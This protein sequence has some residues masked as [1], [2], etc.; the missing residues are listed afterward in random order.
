MELNEEELFAEAM[1]ADVLHLCGIFTVKG[2]LYIAVYEDGQTLSNP[3][4]LSE[5]KENNDTA[6][7]QIVT[8]RSGLCVK[9]PRDLLYRLV[10][11][12]SRNLYAKTYTTL[13]TERYLS[14]DP[15]PEE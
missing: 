15:M 1:R 11:A 13:A 12:D 2:N 10:E 4:I 6:V 7:K 5:M 8:L 14:Y 3:E 9:T